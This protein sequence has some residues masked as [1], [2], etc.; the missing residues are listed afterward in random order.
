MIVQSHR[1]AGRLGSDNTLEAFEMG[2]AMGAVPEA[3]VR[4]TS[5]GV[6][7][8][9]HDS[10]PQRVA[11]DA[12]SDLRGL[13]VGELTWDQLSELDVGAWRGPEFAGQR[14]PRVDAIF[15]A[16]HGRTERMLYIDVKDVA[17][18]RVA[19]L[20]REIGVEKQI[21]LA[22]NRYEHIREWRRIVP[23]GETLLWLGEPEPRRRE[24][25]ADLVRVGFEAIT[26]LQFHVWVADLCAADPFEPSSG[27]IRETAGEARGRGILFQALPWNAE[28]IEVYHRLMDLGVESFASDD[29]RMALEAMRAY[30]A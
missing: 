12:P 17:L 7:V 13:T 14:V 2:W 20:A 4:T 15:R 30:G 27:F 5:D 18:D 29:P 11:P 26:Q 24:R 25:V 6:L 23:E 22:S 19:A 8:A 16:L 10:T 21:I 1:G 9:F 3:D 28:S